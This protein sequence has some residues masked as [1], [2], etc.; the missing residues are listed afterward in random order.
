MGLWSPTTASPICAPT[1]KYSVALLRGASRSHASS[2]EG[3]ATARTSGE[4]TIMRL[5]LDAL[6]TAKQSPPLPPHR[7][8]MQ[9]L[10]GG[11]PEEAPQISTTS[12]RR[13]ITSARPAHR[14]SCFTARMISSF[15]SRQP[16]A[17][18]RLWSRPG[19]RPSTSSSPAPST[20]ST[21]CTH[22]SRVPPGRRR[23]GSSAHRAPRPAGV[24]HAARLRPRRFA[25]QPGADQ[26][27]DRQPLVGWGCGDH[28]IGSRSRK[29]GT[30]REPGCPS[31]P[32]PRRGMS[33]SPFR[34]RCV[35]S[36]G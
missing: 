32:P 34:A 3:A 21:C 10:V 5:L 27:R 12:P 13:S 14:P 30:R 36:P 9:D 17:C 22:R 35:G 23:M 29:R 7:Q 1:D 6:L 8:M 31:P 26:R 20:D 4:L 16:A 28:S 11:Q 33:G 24:R 19:C 25:G 15:P 18:T 2:C